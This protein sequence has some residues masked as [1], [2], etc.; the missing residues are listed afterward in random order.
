MCTADD[1]IVFPAHEIIFQN[2]RQREIK[3]LAVQDRFHLG[4]AAFH[5]VPDH[6]H[7]GVSW[8]VF[9]AIAFL[10]RDAFFFQKGRHR[11]INIFV[12][13]ANLEAPLSERRRHRAHGRPTN[14]EEMKSFRRLLHA[15]SLRRV[16]NF[17]S[18]T[19]SHVRAD[20]RAGQVGFSL[21]I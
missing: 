9:G 2:F 6:H 3:K 1:E 4:I 13:S 10:E 14:P 8:N 15:H 17:A 12:R 11:R 20:V 21:D 5:G 7:I 16:A 18:E 19:K